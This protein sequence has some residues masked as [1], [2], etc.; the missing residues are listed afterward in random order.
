LEEVYGEYVVKVNPIKAIEALQHVNMNEF[1]ESVGPIYEDPEMRD[2]GGLNW[3]SVSTM[4]VVFNQ[5]GIF[6]CAWDFYDYTG[7]AHGNYGRSY[8]SYNLKTGKPIA[9]SSVLVPGKEEEFRQK[10]VEAVKQELNLG[11]QESL[12]DK[13][14]YEEEVKPSNNF[15]LTHKGIGFFFS[16]YEIAP[17]AVGATE[18]FIPY[19][20]CKGLLQLDSDWYSNLLEVQ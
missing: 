3:S 12:A 19:K 9:L 1:K 15:Y 5:Q 14:Y 7:G 13:G 16:P 4:A 2:V 18:I 8:H 10:M 6:S 11:P 20:E 17:Y